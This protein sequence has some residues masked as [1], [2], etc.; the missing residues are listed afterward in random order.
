MADTRALS[1]PFPV[2]TNPTPT[3]RLLR[4]FDFIESRPAGLT[5]TTRLLPEGKNSLSR[6]EAGRARGTEGLFFSVGLASREKFRIGMPI[7]KVQGQKYKPSALRLS[8]NQVE[9]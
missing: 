2:N 9:L 4:D 1:L 3:R 6:L 7:S 8:F 5:L